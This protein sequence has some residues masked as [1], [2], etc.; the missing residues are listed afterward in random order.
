MF[1]LTLLKSFALGVWSIKEDNVVESKAVE[2]KKEKFLQVGK[3][4]Q[5]K[6]Q[7]GDSRMIFTMIHVH[8]SLHQCKEPPELQPVIICRSLT[9]D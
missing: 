4:K 8:L 3:Q 1:Y 7:L 2:Q 5:V 6:F 9:F